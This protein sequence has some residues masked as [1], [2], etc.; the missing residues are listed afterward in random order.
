MNAVRN[1]V[2]LLVYLSLFQVH[3]Q[4]FS[5]RHYNVENGLHQSQIST[6]AQDQSG[7]LYLGSMSGGISRF[8]GVNFESVHSDVLGSAV[9]WKIIVDSK[10]RLWIASDAGLFMME[11]GALKRFS[12]EDGF[13]SDE[14][15]SLFES[16][17]NEIWIGTKDKGLYVYNDKNFY[18]FGINDGL[19]FS[20]VNAIGQDPKGNIWVGSY[21]YGLA[22]IVNH[23]AENVTGISGINSKIIYD[24]KT[25]IDGVFLCAS[26]DGL[27][28]LNEGRFE[29]SR[30][31]P[32]EG[33]NRIIA[34]EQDAYGAIWLATED[35]GMFLFDSPDNY[36]HLTDNSGLNTN[37]LF[38][39]FI[40]DQQNLWVGSDGAGISL[41]SGRMFAYL[42][43][44]NGL[45]SNQVLALMQDHNKNLW[46]GTDKGIDVVSPK[47]EIKQ[48]ELQDGHIDRYINRIYE[49]SK[50]RIWVGTEVGLC[51]IDKDDSC[52]VDPFKKITGSVFTFYE[53]NIDE[54]WIGGDDGLWVYKGDSLSRLVNQK[55]PDDIVF[56]IFGDSKGIKWVLLSESIIKIDGESTTSL[57]LSKEIKGAFD[58]TEDEGGNYYIAHQA[59]I[60][61]MRPDGT[62]G[63]IDNK[64]GLASNSVYFC[65]YVDGALWV[66]HQWGVDKLKLNNDGHPLEVRHY[67]NSEGFS[68]L[69][70]NDK[71]FLK[72]ISGNY[73]IGTV[74]GAFRLNTKY[75]K[76]LVHA[77]HLILKKLNVLHGSIDWRTEYPDWSVKN[78]LPVEPTFQHEHNHISF[79]FVGIDF[80]DPAGI[81]YQ[82]MLEGYDEDWSPPSPSNKATYPNLPPGIYTFKVKAG[83]LHGNWSETI[84]YSFEVEGPFWTK[85]WFYAL[86]IPLGVL[87]ICFVMVYRT[88]RLT[89]SK[90]RLEEVVRT[91]TVELRQN[92]KRLEQLSIVA[93]EIY[94]GVLIC[95][96]TGKIEW[97][98]KSFY[99]MAGYETEEQFKQSKYGKIEN[100]QELSSL[101]NIDAVIQL[102]ENDPLPFKYD[103]AHISSSGKE[104]WTAGT[105]T[106]IYSENNTLINIVG[107]YTDITK[108]KQVELE[109]LNKNKELEKLSMIAKRMNEAVLICDAFGKIEYYN[110]GFVRNSGYTKEEFVMV[111]EE[112]KT[113]QEFSS[114][115]KINE[116]VI[117]FQY[118]KETVFYDSFHKR[119]DESI[120]WTTASLT[121]VY[122]NDVLSNI[123]VVYTDITERRNISNRLQQTNKDITDSIK[124]AKQI[125]R[126]VLPDINIMTNV[127]PDSFVFYK[128]RD[129]VSG[130]FYWFSLVRGVLIIAAADC[131]GHGVPGAF[132]SMIGN[133]FLHQI[134]NNSQVDYP[135]QALEKLDEMIIRALHQ[136]TGEGSQTTKDGMDI[137]LC[138]I[139]LESKMCQFAGAFNPLYLVRDNEVVVHSAVKEAIGGSTAR[140]KNFT[141]HEFQL[142]SN[143]RIYLL[144]DGFTDQFGGP[145]NKKFT[146]R[147]FRETLLEL[148]DIP[149]TQQEAKFEEIYKNWV[150]NQKQID[151]MLIIGLEIP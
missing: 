9:I 83:N 79:D 127:Y 107:I 74:L 27:W 121:P 126:A 72:D 42:N 113:L 87:L 37:Y 52:I 145:R 34:I 31:N 77:P 150:G 148:K 142:Q 109:L 2:F 55:I 24:F 119:K 131:T 81:L 80:K 56:Y 14:V 114:N 130:D 117:G 18:H 82:Y 43:R 116:I 96:P 39:L 68:G 60:L 124:Y 1:I 40:D 13:K 76:P 93:R 73:W 111:M 123:V 134:V 138:A 23:K 36:V 110:F 137:A 92:N 136:E 149:M 32:I 144:S 98:N 100:I 8:D 64:N 95:G 12:D 10:G 133:E 53:N 26:E 5:F 70:T 78:N 29:K 7:L 28:E 90:R 46:F 35:N 108:R 54:I 4:S 11:D 20:S 71:A 135:H 62:F 147:R 3:S 94:D 30:Y 63:T 45:S 129:I 132:M 50:N 102:F 75:D 151:D 97:Y 38:S 25:L 112:T 118:S 15:W 99:Q 84:S 17:Q 65:K 128:P 69:E 67:G 105:L 143:D 125:Q 140:D 115:E 47:F 57:K 89:R 66:G 41:F 86:V 22:K 91:R 101:E 106:P 85:T 139:H 19:G 61:V 58:M 120:M 48:I 59:G 21:G 6:I 146:R 33:N 49:D 51:K 122:K 44:S 88:R 104:R 141:S 16:K 103:S